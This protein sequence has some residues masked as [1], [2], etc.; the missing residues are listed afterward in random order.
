ME[1]GLYSD[2][3]VLLLPAF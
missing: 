1:G 3:S 2:M